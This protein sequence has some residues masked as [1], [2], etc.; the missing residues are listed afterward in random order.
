[1]KSIESHKCGRCKQ[2]KPISE[3]Y[4]SNWTCK[5]CTSEDRKIFYRANIDRMKER[6][7]AFYD[8]HFRPYTKKYLKN[9]NN[10]RD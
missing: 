9:E 10:N 8:K 6:R 4:S 5:V 1:M 3:F 2:D 7:K